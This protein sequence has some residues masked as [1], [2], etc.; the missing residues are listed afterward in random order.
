M[1]VVSGYFDKVSEAQFRADFD[2]HCRLGES[3]E[4][5]NELLKDVPL[6]VRATEH[7]CGY[8]FYCPFDFCIEPGERQVIPTG[9]RFIPNTDSVWLML[10]P[11]SSLGVKYGMVLPNT[12]GVIDADYWQSMNEGHI[13]V[14]VQ[15]TSDSVMVIH[16]GD[17]IVQGIILPYCVTI[18][19]NQVSKGVRIGGTGSTGK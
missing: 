19:D 11:R 13:M 7:S 12:I 15:N 16:S 17:R 14:Y 9:I 10:V 4:D 3:D 2:A 6:P 8:D 5:I 18:D 1:R